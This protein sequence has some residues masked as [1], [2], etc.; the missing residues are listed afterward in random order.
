MKENTNTTYGVVSDGGGGATMRRRRGVKLD[1]FI[2]PIFVVDDAK[3]VITNRRV[4]L[5][6][7]QTAEGGEKK[8]AERKE[9]EKR[10]YFFGK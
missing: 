6:K 9:K 10:Y 3:N 2:A 4:G 5:K 1:A 7:N 8:R